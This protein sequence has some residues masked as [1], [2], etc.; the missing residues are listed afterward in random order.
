MA[1]TMGASPVIVNGPVRER[2]GMNMKLGA[3]GQGNRANAT[4][5]RA[6]QLIIRNVGGAKPVVRNGQR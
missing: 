5:G 3:L 2:L 1:T 4:I 6:V